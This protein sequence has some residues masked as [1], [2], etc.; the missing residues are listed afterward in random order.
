M[1]TTCARKHN[2]PS[3]HIYLAATLTGAYS[4]KS[5]WARV[6]HRSRNKSINNNQIN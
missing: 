2:E 5:I 1:Q 6:C 3:Q 4:W